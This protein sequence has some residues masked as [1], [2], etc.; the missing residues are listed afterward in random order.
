MSAC[1]SIGRKSTIFQKFTHPL[2]MLL[3]FDKKLDTQN[4]KLEEKM[5]VKLNDLMDTICG[6][7]TFL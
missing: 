5:I 2:Y 6:L 7:R 3:P 1:A 4:V